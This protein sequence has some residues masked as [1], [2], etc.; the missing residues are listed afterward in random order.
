MDFRIE[1][2][3]RRPLSDVERDLLDPE[4]ISATGALPKLHDCVVL[5]RTD[6]GDEVRLR[7][8][9]R[10]AADLPAVVTAV[11]DPARL[12]WVEEIA[13]D[14]T[15]HRA[16][17]RIA[18]DHYADRLRCSYTTSLVERD[19]ITTRVAV[20]AL[21]VKALL[22]ARPI[23]QA[24]VSGLREYAEAE[25]TLLETWVPASDEPHPRH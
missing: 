8:H 7:V 16:S 5:D 12:T 15:T 23:E 4:F 22:A 13:H 21:T 17:H 6:R 14:R 2:R 19:G 24:I 9:R 10:F 18:P 20:G 25:A 3:I 11:I 1:Q